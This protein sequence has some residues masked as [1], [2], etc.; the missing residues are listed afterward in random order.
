MDQFVLTAYWLMMQIVVI[1]GATIDLFLALLRPL[2]RGYINIIL[3][4]VR[5]L[6]PAL[7]H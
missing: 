7:P 5:T 3:V 1:I 2:N 4:T 6:I